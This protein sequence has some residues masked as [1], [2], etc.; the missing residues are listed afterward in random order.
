MLMLAWSGQYRRRPM[1]R[2]RL[3][4]MKVRKRI[5]SL[6]AA[7]SLVS[8]F[9]LPSCY[10]LDQGT[11]YLGILAKAKPLARV[12]DKASSPESERLFL[13]RVARI[14]AF[15]ISRLGL[16]DTKNY[17]SLVELGTASL[18]TVVQACDELSFTR[19]LYSYPVVGKLPYKGFFKPEAA[20]KEAQRLKAQGLD[21]LVRDVSAFSTLGWF[22]DPLF[23]FMESYSEA[24]LADLLLH[25]LTH[26][27]AFSKA[28]GD[29]NEEVATFVGRHAAEAYLLDL[30]GPASPSLA[31][32]RLSRQRSETFAAFMRETGAELEAVYSS[33]A[34]PEEKRRDKAAII[35]ARAT[36]YKE[37]GVELFGPGPDAAGWRGYEM[38]GINNAW[39]DLYHLYEGENELYADYLKLACGGELEVFIVKIKILAKARDPKAEMRKE[40]GKP[41]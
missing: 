37:K 38:A 12:R 33:S 8:L 29:W 15:G 31:E 41:A 32:A 27:T 25:E 7:L 14:R 1:P 10:V 19:Y 20:H 40:L 16:A 28:P 23:S 35:A 4:P 2:A 26:A 5:P 13:D 39:L 34:S 24:E 21:V 6:L 3:G 11:A 17:T 18:A 9:T 36:I 30:E 22:R